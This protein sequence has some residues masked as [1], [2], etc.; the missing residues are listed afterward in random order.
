M[1]QKWAEMKA[2][3]QSSS[4]IWGPQDPTFTNEENN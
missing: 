1:K 3:R 2:K 4:N